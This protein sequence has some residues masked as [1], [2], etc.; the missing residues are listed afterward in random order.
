VF[1]P[2]LAGISKREAYVSDGVLFRSLARGDANLVLRN[3][4]L[5]LWPDEE[6]DGAKEMK[7]EAFL[8]ELREVFPFVDIKVEFDKTL[9]EQINV[10]I[11]TN[12]SD[13]VPLEIVGT[14]VLQATQILS[15]IHRF[16]PSLMVL[17]EPD[18]HLHPD[19]QRLL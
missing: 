3:I 17:D 12:G 6:S 1:S 16:Q 7:W 9:D 5:R 11:T 15:Y 14:S 2:G 19:N 13:W 18:S 8:T 10:L 4:L